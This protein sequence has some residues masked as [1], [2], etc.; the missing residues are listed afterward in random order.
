MSDDGRERGHSWKVTYARAELAR[1]AAERVTTVEKRISLFEA[2][3]IDQSSNEE[4][5][6][7][8]TTNERSRSEIGC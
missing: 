5:R 1:A 3:I 4:E 6:N 7:G 2:K 8:V